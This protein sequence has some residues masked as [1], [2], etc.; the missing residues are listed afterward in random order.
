MAHLLTIWTQNLSET[1][2]QRHRAQIPR[3]PSFHHRC[4][5]ELPVCLHACPSFH[6]PRHLSCPDNIHLR[7]LWLSRFTKT[8]RFSHQTD[9]FQCLF[10]DSLPPQNFIFP[11]LFPRSPHTPELHPSA[12]VQHTLQ[13]Y[14]IFNLPLFSTFRNAPPATFV[15]HTLH[16][17][18][19]SISHLE[20]ST[21]KHQ[22]RL[23]ILLL[24][25][26][27]CRFTSTPITPFF[28][29]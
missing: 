26:S 20:Q 3:A 5:P 16:Q 2:L 29:S 6:Q 10:P 12:F 8:T 28:L 24:P 15:H 21:S 23:R 4:P 22:S 9:T 27:V 1:H 7:L 17:I 11:R 19:S 13:Q 18:H 14:S 25:S